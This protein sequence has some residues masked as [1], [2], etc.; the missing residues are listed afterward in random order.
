MF[1]FLNI[2]KNLACKVLRLGWVAIATP[3]LPAQCDPPEGFYGIGNVVSY[4]IKK[5]AT[6]IDKNQSVPAIY[7]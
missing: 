4:S 6:T 7:I 3:S 1:L 5:A 2:K